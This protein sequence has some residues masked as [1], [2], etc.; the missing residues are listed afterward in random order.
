MK[1][2]T[3][4]GIRDWFSLVG[5]TTLLGWVIS[6]QNPFLIGL[7]LHPY[8][9]VTSLIAGRYG[10]RQGVVSA[11]ALSSI[12]AMGC[13]LENGLIGPPPLL[14]FPHSLVIAGLFAFAITIGGVLGALRERIAELTRENKEWKDRLSFADEQLRVFEKANRDLR[15]RIFE[16]TT[17]FSTIVDMAKKL[18]NLQ[19]VEIYPAVLDILS[20]HLEAES[21]SF[22]LVEGEMLRLVAEKGWGVV[23]PEQSHI[24]LDRGVLG[25]VVREN[26]LI[27]LKDLLYQ[28]SLEPGDKV[29]AVPV[30]AVEGGGVIGVIAIEKIPFDKFNAQTVRALSTVAKWAANALAHAELFSQREKEVEGLAYQTQSEGVARHLILSNLLEQLQNRN[31]PVSSIER[32][33]QLGDK[34]LP[35]MQS[36]M[37]KPSTSPHE[38]NNV[39]T[40][41]EYLFRGGHMLRTDIYRVSA[42]AGFRDWFRLEQYRIAASAPGLADSTD[43]LRGYIQEQQ[44][45]I[46]LYS[47]RMVRLMLAVEFENKT[48]FTRAVREGKVQLDPALARIVGAINSG[49]PKGILEAGRDQFGLEP[50]SFEDVV[51]KLL[52]SPDSLLRAATLHALGIG[53]WVAAQWRRQILKAL[54]D[55]NEIVRETAV[56]ALARISTVDSHAEI[57]ESIRARMADESSPIV[58]QAVEYCTAIETSC[59][60]SGDTRLDPNS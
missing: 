20:Q 32:I 45:E 58:R 46:K 41:L 59:M 31:P 16:E 29:V 4:M 8:H 9:V 13:L 44:V 39:V 40:V 34:V 23:E 35:R 17:T 28:D 27:S 49:D 1:V 22:Y 2:S 3:R 57:H 54:E 25:Q 11:A 42:V 52:T 21:C 30:A 14:T 19:P 55:P 10:T 26:R 24:P 5:L 36:A 60:G 15:G 38:R 18:D 12:Y 47:K 33:A 37:V 56:L 48:E 43:V 7:A 50:V 51:E 53:P 6:P